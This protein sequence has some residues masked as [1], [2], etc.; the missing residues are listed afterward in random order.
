MS[1][2]APRMGSILGIVSEQRLWTGLLATSEYLQP[3]RE[4]GAATSRNVNRSSM[5]AI[6]VTRNLPRARLNAAP[7]SEAPV[8]ILAEHVV[9][10]LPY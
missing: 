10:M 2:N 9:S 3:H 8:D 4:F 7:V 1:S 5:S 6:C